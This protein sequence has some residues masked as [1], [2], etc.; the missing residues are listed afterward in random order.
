MDV[1]L[2]ILIEGSVKFI[3]VNF[4]NFLDYIYSKITTTMLV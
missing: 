2:I 3:V 4:M 1:E